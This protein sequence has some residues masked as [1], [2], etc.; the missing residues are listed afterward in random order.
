MGIEAGS[1]TYYQAKRG[2]VQ[3]GLVL[4]LDAGVKES[5]SGGTTF[6]DMK[7]GN[8]LTL[9]NGALGGRVNGGGIDFDGTDDYAYKTGLSYTP[10]CVDVWF[11]NDID[12]TKDNK[13]GG[14]YEMIL[15]MGNYPGGISCRAFTAAMTDET[16]GFWTPSYQ[17]N[18]ATYI[19]DN[20]YSGDHNLTFNW[21]GSTYDIWLDGVKR[22]TYAYT[23]STTP[24]HANLISRNSV[25]L[26]RSST[27]YSY[28]FDGIIY[29][30]AIY[31]SQLTDSQVLQNFNALRHR[32]G[33]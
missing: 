12:I 3:D 8:N 28:N 24:I 25:Y 26:G 22:T 9:A 15:G 31:S 5:Y 4:H 14:G 17:T 27:V 33:V 32:F 19:R 11:H 18:G 23:P 20:V 30:L 1:S 21:N 2:T 7:S 6:I 29:C 10:Y 16:I 13:P